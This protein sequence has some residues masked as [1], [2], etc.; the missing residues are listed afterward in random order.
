MKLE[1]A[2]AEVR[3]AVGW[4]P[5]TSL[6][7]QVER[8][9]VSSRIPLARSSSAARCACSVEKDTFSRTSTGA[10]RKFRPTRTISMRCSALLEIAVVLGKEEVHHPEVHNHENE[11]E[12]AQFGGSRPTPSRRARQTK[13]DDVEQEH[14]QRKDVF[15]VE[16]GIV[17]REIAVHG[18]KTERRADKDGDEADHDAGVAHALQEFEG[19]Q[20]PDHITETPDA[21][22]AFLTQIDK[23]E[24]AG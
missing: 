15:R 7:L 14:E 19:R 23:A 11:V 12:D 21:Q 22:Q 4:T 18:D 9:R 17:L 10:V 3:F 6:R 24:D 2:A 8:T 20:A 5:Y 1:S 16:I 13:I